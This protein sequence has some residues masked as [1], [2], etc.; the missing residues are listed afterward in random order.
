MRDDDVR[1]DP[2]MVMSILFTLPFIIVCG[3]LFLLMILT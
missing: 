3:V 1:D 2:M